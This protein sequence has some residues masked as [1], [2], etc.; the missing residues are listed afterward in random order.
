M[1]TLTLLAALSLGVFQVS[2]SRA[3]DAGE[4]AVRTADAARLLAMVA[5]DGAALGRVLSEEMMFMHSDGRLENKADY[6]KNLMRGDTAYADAKTTSLRTQRVSPDV[7]VLTGAQS[8]RKKLGTE[9]STINL[10]FLSVWRNEAGTW[11]MV[12]WQSMRPAG[13]SVVP[14]ATGSAPVQPR[15]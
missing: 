6:V 1:K 4:S 5:G 11:R 9:W 8:M 15:Q 13:N 10:R 12:A 14:P 3:A 2:V 7:I